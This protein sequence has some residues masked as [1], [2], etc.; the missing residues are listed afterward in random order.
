MYIR[1]PSQNCISIPVYNIDFVFTNARPDR[2]KIVE[3]NC[4]SEHK[5]KFV[6]LDITVYKGLRVIISLRRQVFLQW[7]VFLFFVCFVVVVF[8]FPS[9]CP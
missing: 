9:V 5:I 4:I 2:V 7:F 8:S 1:K 6:F 3:R